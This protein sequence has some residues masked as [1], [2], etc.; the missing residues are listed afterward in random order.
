MKE[1]IEAVQRMQ[2]YIKEHLGEPITLADLS[3]ASG[4]SPWYAHRL[5][6]QHL[7]RSPADYIRRCRLAASALSLRDGRARVLDAALDAGYESA[8]GYQR[9]FFREFGCNPGEYAQKPV[10]IPL[11]VP[12]RLISSDDTDREGTNMEKTKNIFVQ[13]TERPARKVVIKRGIAAEDYYAYCEEVGCDVY[14][15][16]LSMKSMLGEPVSLWLPD[17]YIKPGTSR[18]VQGVEVP[19]DEDPE[20]PEGYDVISLPKAAYLM[21]V[22]EPFEEEF[23][24]QAID[25][26]WKAEKKYNPRLIGYEWDP[27]NPRIQLEP[28]GSRGYIEYVAVRPM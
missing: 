5:F 19:P 27:D 12:Y 6:L 1:H 10:P 18:Y 16:L 26:I 15:M 21:F 17:K 3:R 14:G 22:G 11:F 7:S 24:E 8:E 23:F 25:E 9:A 20:V 13:L 4:Y 2:D 28:V